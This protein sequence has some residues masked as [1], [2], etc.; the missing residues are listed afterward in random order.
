[1]IKEIEFIQYRRLKAP[2][3]LTFGERI[4]VISGMNGTCK[5]SILYLISNSFQAE[6][7]NT[8]KLEPNVELKLINA[9]SAQINAK[10]ESLTKGDQEYNNPAP[11]V[12]GSLF[13]VKYGDETSLSF[14]RHN[15]SDEKNS[16]FRIIPDYTEK[17]Q[18]LPVL[19]TVYLS[20]ARLL[21]FGEINDDTTIRTVRNEL[22]DEYNQ[23]FHDLV[24]EVTGISINSSKSQIIERVKTRSTYQT[25]EEGIDSNTVSAGED[26]VIVILKN[27]VLLRYYYEKSPTFHNSDHSCA[28][29]LLVDEIDATLHP[30]MQLR[31]LYCLIEYS[32]NYKIQVFFTTHSLFLLEKLLAPTYKKIVSVNYLT[33][34]GDHISLLPDPSIRKIE[35]HLQENLITSYSHTPKIPIFT[36]DPEARIIL[37]GIF[38]YFDKHCSYFKQVRQHFHFVEASIGC[39]VLKQIFQDTYLDT[40]TMNAICILDG[41][42][43]GQKQTKRNIII[44]PSGK[45]PERMIFDYGKELTEER[46]FWM[47]ESPLS[48]GFT[49]KFYIDTIQHDIDE[50]TTKR[51]EAKAKQEST[52]GAE[53][54]DN[55]RIFNH[56]LEKF[57]LVLD[58]WLNNHH[59][60]L[61]AF[62]RD[63]RYCFRQVAVLHNIDP[64]LWPIY[65]KLNQKI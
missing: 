15:N 47:T 44:L 50:A 51:L 41:D 13:Q 26:N 49:K 20:L 3:K 54:E 7:L 59:V 43:T 36:E 45:N 46:A 64:E 6:N 12:K 48:N 1:M 28:S 52:K 40:N 65:S 31:L 55:K 30:A 17:G 23:A 22:P 25:N 19:R 24:R 10:I 4:N 61:E 32:E 56:H 33:H 27:L 29:I 62:Y 42:N 2:L 53:R 11:N 9:I 39:E 57:R 14:R 18:S 5:S 58:Y 37:N 38:G 8:T 34:Q 63:L 16:R 35:L 21:P 60:E